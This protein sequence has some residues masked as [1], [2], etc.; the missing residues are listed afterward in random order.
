M[1]IHL[2]DL[3]ESARTLLREQTIEL[4]SWAS[5]TPGPAFKVFPSPGTPRNAYEKIDDAAQVHRFTGI[6][7]AGVPAHPLGHGRR[8]P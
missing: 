6:T 2:S 7:P 8:L 5:A 4:P 3:S 1:T